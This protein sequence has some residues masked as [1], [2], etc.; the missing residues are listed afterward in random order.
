MKTLHLMLINAFVAVFLV[1]LL[2]FVLVLQ[3]LDLFT[4]LWRYL[5][6]DVGL[7]QLLRIGFFYLPKCV[8]YSLAPALLFSV[9]FTL[10]S[11]H[12]NNEL[13][14]VLGSGVS[15]LRLVA[16]FFLVGA[17][18]SVG[19]FFFE[20]RVVIDTLA[21]K[22]ALFRQAVKQEV[23]LSNT[24]VTVI[25]EDTT[26]VYQVDYYNDKRQTFTQALIIK[27]DP[28][29][30]LLQRIDAEAGEWNGTNWVLRNCKIYSWEA[31]EVLALRRV[32][33][34]DAVELRDP[35][36]T[37]RR[38]TS[39]IEEMKSAEA[40][41]WVTNLRRA[42]LPYRGA[43]TEYYAKFFFALN[44]LIVALIATGVGG[45]FKKNVLLMNLLAALVA[46]VVY[47][48]IQMMAV[49][50]AKNGYI[51]PLAGAG[52]GFVVFLALAGLALRTART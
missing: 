29:G 9:A 12:R 14:A 20:E 39:N 35:P 43:L 45:R 28:E 8:S 36:A 3:L 30:R 40:L 27:R 16:P 24:N 18:L 31:G 42:G 34:Y 46:S 13:I 47:Y 52:L 48:V 10:G 5:A 37:F 23:S 21:T 50:L 51:P 11:L 22:N 26:T 33:V 1:A 7:G 15:L 49:I 4:N 2:F 32:P 6:Q 19:G 25:G 38:T 17:L 41:G 44:P